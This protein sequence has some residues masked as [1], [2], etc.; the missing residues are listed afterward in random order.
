MNA[1]ALYVSTCRYILQADFENGESWGDLYRLLPYLRQSLSCCVCG[2]LLN[3]P[4]GPT[5]SN[6]QHFVCRTCVGGKMLLKPS[7][8]WCKNYDKFAEVRQLRI[9]LS[10]YKKLC[11]YIAATP[12][13][14]SFIGTNGES[15]STL[16]ILQEG[17]AINTT[18]GNNSAG[19]DKNPH[20][21]DILARVNREKTE[22]ADTKS[23][24]RR[25]G[26]PRRDREGSGASPNPHLFENPEVLSHTLDSPL[27]GLCNGLDS[28][29]QF[30]MS[31]DHSIYS[32]S[33]SSCGSPRIKIKR[34]RLSN[35]LKLKIKKKKKKH[36]KIKE[37]TSDREARNERK[38]RRHRYRKASDESESPVDSE[39][40][41]LVNGD[42]TTSSP[43]EDTP[44]K[45]SVV[46]SGHR[47]KLL[48]M[49]RILPT[50]VGCR[51][52][53]WGKT[54]GANT[55]RGNRCP[56]FMS[57]KGCY[58]CKCKGC[59]NPIPPPESP[60]PKKRQR[61]SFRTDIHGEN[62]L[63]TDANDM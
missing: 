58:K 61:H 30:D 34:K 26:R 9:L 16:T 8:S 23:P 57:E 3:D 54:P 25:R 50:V 56:C 14:R 51:C 11:E 33:F 48:K 40:E 44:R 60:A 6:C 62:E 55:C 52:G 12:I 38:R 42:W 19:P 15:N 41:K 37:R 32:A 13:A 49:G 18:H 24:G 20:I 22:N 4:R 36:D 2:S 27:D 39:K 59:R 63:D 47:A 31:S 53:T 45:Q 35:D 5:D 17:M 28:S 29:D 10:C 7:C 1:T 21:L 43:E 46:I